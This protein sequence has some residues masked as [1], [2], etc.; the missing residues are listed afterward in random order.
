MKLTERELDILK[1]IAENG[2][3]DVKITR[4]IMKQGNALYERIW[5]LEDMDCI[6][7]KRKTGFASL[8][9]LTEY[10]GQLLQEKLFDD[11]LTSPNID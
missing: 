7:V 4:R 9:T 8:H 5:K 3:T 6:I 11:I 2:Y 10:G 1:H